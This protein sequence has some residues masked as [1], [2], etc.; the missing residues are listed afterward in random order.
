MKTDAWDARHMARLLHTE[1]IVAVTV[2]DAATQAAR[3]L[4]RPG[5]TCLGI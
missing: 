1:Q 4:D 2:P 5:R 3:D